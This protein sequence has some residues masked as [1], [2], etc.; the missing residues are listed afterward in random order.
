MGGMTLRLADELLLLVYDDAG[1]MQASA[2]VVD[3]G[4]AGALLME[5]MLAERLAVPD[6]RLVVTD[7]SPVG[8]PL[9]DQALARIAAD[10][11][12]RKP[13]DWVGPLSGG[14]RERVLDRLVDAGLLRREEDR[15]LWV[16]PRTRFPS[17]SGAEPLPEGEARRRLLAAVDASGPV[18][19]RTA[20]LCALVRAVGIERIAVPDRPRREV[21]DRFQEIV[22]ISWPADAV[23]KAITEMEAAVTTAVIVATTAATTS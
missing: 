2:Q 9:A 7:P 18:D 17:A 22:E 23:R 11:R 20:A 14:L 10:R 4:L 19:E 5:L 15:V 3:Y 8:D 6:K 16:F 21:R 13:K 1:S 12:G